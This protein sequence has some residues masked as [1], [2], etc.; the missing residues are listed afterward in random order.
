MAYLKPFSKLDMA[1][2]YFADDVPHNAVKSFAH[3]LFSVG[4]VAGTEVVVG[5]VTYEFVAELSDDPT[6]PNEILRTGV[7]ATDAENFALAINGGERTVGSEEYSDG[8][9]AHPLVEAVY[10]EGETTVLVQAK[11]PGVEGDMIGVASG[12]VKIAFEDAEADGS[13][14][15]E[16]TGGRLATPAPYAIAYI[17]DP[18]IAPNT[19]VMTTEP[20]DV[21]DTDKWKTYVLA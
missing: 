3:A 6:V 19:I 20:V 16:L 8:T 15:A 21:Q 18:K 7:A 9:V 5:D 11:K 4:V 13:A 14:V 2:K 10:E 1:D 12:D 17:P